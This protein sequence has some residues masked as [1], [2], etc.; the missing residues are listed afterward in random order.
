MLQNRKFL[1]W[2]LLA[3]FTIVSLISFFGTTTTTT[4]ADALPTPTPSGPISLTIIQHSSTILS[5][6]IH[7]T[8]INKYICVNLNSVIS[9]PTTP[10]Q[11]TYNVGKAST[12]Y[13]LTDKLHLQIFL[14]AKCKG[15]Q[16]KKSNFRDTV[17]N[18]L[19]GTSSSSSSLL[20]RTE[21]S[22]G[23]Q[24]GIELEQKT[25]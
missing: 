16:T 5:V 25:Q 7:N 4:L 24:D 12:T 6:L 23:A 15:A 1:T 22:P 19:G 21:S 3:S 8:T 10:T 2:M 18:L 9:N 14:S 20:A 13:Q 11:N 17:S